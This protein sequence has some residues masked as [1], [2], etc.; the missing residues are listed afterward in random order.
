[1]IMVLIVTIGVFIVVY[2][3]AYFNL[4]RQQL[5]NSKEVLDAIAKVED[6][7]EDIEAAKK[8]YIVYTFQQEIHEKYKDIYDF[9][10]TSPYSKIKDKKI[11]QFKDIYINMASYIKQWNNEYIQLEL[12]ENSSLFDNI[13]G[14]SLDQQQRMAIVTDELNNLIL[15]GAGCGKTLTISGKVNYLIKR[16]NIKPED[17][18]LISFTRKAA[19]EMNKRISKKLGINVD[20]K[21]FHKLGLDIITM[22]NK[23]RPDV[24]DDMERL[25]HKYFKQ[26]IYNNKKMINNIIV[27]F[28]YYLNIPKDWEEFN[29]LGEYHDYY[30]NVDFETLR[31]KVELKNYINRGINNLKVNKRTL[32]GETVKSIEELIIANF[33]FLNGINYIY[34]YEYPFKS[35]DPYR[36]KYTP[37]FYLPDY[38]IY[39]E[40][41]GI[42]ENNRAPWLTPIEEKKYLD[43]IKWK[44]ETHRK[45][46]TV[47][48]ET[49]SYYNKQGTL[50]L[51]LENALKKAGVK[52]KDVDYE[53]IYK[54]IYDQ[55][56]DKYFE[57]FIKLICSF[58]RL[59][60][61]NGYTI[62]SFNHLRE[63]IMDNSNMF[64]R[65]RN[66]LFLNI[67]K[68]IYQYYQAF[69]QRN[70]KIDF[71]DMINLA[72]EIIESN[73]C[74][75]N[76][77]YII[78]D[79][80]QDIS[81][82][83][84]RLIKAIRDK[85]NAKL[86]CVGDDWQSIFRFAGS[87]IDLFT[88]FEKYFGYCELLKIEKTYR[89]SQEL[90]DIAGKFIMRNKN[91]LKKDLK[92][93]KHNSNP[94][95]ILGYNQDIFTAIKKAINE[96]VHLFGKEA[97]ILMLGRN[98]FDIDFIDSDEEF[99][100][101]RSSNEHVKVK[102][103]K[104][105]N[106][107]I[108]FLTVHKSK[109]LEA[110][111]VII[112]NAENKLLGFPNK[113]SDDPVLSLVLTDVDTYPYAEERRLFYV[114]LTRTRNS[115][116]IITP[117][118]RRSLFVD[119]LINYCKV[120]YEFST[121]EESIHENP[122]CPK[123]QKGYLTIRVNELTNQKFIGCTNYPFCDLTINNIEVINDQVI[124]RSCG[125]YM[126]KRKSSYGEYYGCT[127]YPYCTQTIRI[128]SGILT[129][130]EKFK[131]NE[132]I[133]EDILTINSLLSDKN[134]LIFDCETTGLNP[135]N[136]C[137]LSYLICN[138]RSI[139]AK[140]FYFTVDYVEPEAQRVH[141][142]SVNKLRQLSNNKRFK[143]FF[144]EIKDDFCNADLLI[145]HN[146]SFDMKFIKAEFSRQGYKYMPN[147]SFC[148]MRYFTDIC[149]LY[150]QSHRYKYPKLKELAN[151]LNI[152]KYD[153]LCTVKEYYGED[154]ISFHDARFDVTTTFLCFVK[155][156][157]NGH[158]NSTEVLNKL[159]G[160]YEI[161]IINKN[162]IDF[163]NSQS[164]RRLNGIYVDFGDIVY[165]MDT[166][167]EEIYDVKIHQNP[168]NKH[169]MKEIELALLGKKV[170]EGFVY[171]GYK[172]KI[173]EIKKQM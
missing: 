101:I 122:N 8:D 146:Y 64:L 3:I 54:Q 78:I 124:C 10:S 163:H 166:E 98:N 95:R 82:S 164:E 32:Q 56:N 115:T 138:E 7:F 160:R 139:K 43:G 68:P 113:I 27:F 63:K 24:Y 128:D 169:L 71:N 125:G 77:K 112:I 29:N 39:I 34:E 1:M 33:L 127:N 13:D 31:S 173:V 117:E 131:S 90:I 133:K 30:R 60:K 151:F 107:K 51:N 145:A 110:D 83:R 154:S 91:Q 76:Y 16:K 158:I 59:F 136:I 100:L 149:K 135:G 86:M 74:Q 62:G 97:E 99:K 89:N 12:N 116:Y 70:N 102:Y 35:T 9:F 84:F 11:I 153:I 144:R 81:V 129:K 52:F 38:D 53:Q 15:A 67:V 65:Q 50:L 87:D 165:I 57:E 47:L 25:V 36:K 72:T 141:N 80:Y 147:D 40:H 140:N 73:S 134:I 22:N 157:K 5:I 168:H 119:E 14:K 69:L 26:N 137:Q 20:A 75:L 159:K 162:N 152:N 105:P 66:I 114:A 79:E 123:C 109:G 18:L 94:I 155:G 48:L 126:V 6:F 103:K 161:P 118:K 21:T 130:K 93:E 37:D 143:D 41:F 23:Q 88:N 85:T 61:S 49:Y 170:N 4:Q 2:S 55:Q 150:N 111:N 172:Y 106:L 156:I 142:L 19:E 58:I 44:R 28:G 120:K 46:K 132:K 42:N 45:N 17:I 104:Y 121:N 171:K 92:S 148:T 96:I 108:S 167:N